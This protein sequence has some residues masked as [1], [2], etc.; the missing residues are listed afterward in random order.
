MSKTHSKYEK[1][2]YVGCAVLDV[3]ETIM[4]EFFYNV[5]KPL[6]G[7]KVKLCYMDTDNFIIEIETEDIY[8]DI[9]SIVS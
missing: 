1:S 5:L 2:I 3:S 6:Y 4:Y 9:A 8:K 7:D